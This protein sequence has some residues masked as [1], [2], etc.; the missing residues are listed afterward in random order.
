MAHNMSSQIGSLIERRQSA[1][2]PFATPSRKHTPFPQL[3]PHV[4]WSRPAT[5]QAPALELGSAFVPGVLGG[6][7]FDEKARI[8][9]VSL[10]L[11]GAVVLRRTAG[12]AATGHVSTVTHGL[13]SRKKSPPE[14]LSESRTTVG[15]QGVAAAGQTGTRQMAAV[16]W[17]LV[18][19]QQVGAARQ[20]LSSLPDDREYRKLRVLLQPPRTWSAPRRDKD[21][22]ADFRWLRQHGRD[23]VGR[24]VALSDGVLL[25]DDD[26]I[27]ALRN[28]LQQN[29]PHARPLIHLVQ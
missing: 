25:A 2:P 20:L 27:H 1:L 28:Q 8:T 17:S 23:Y 24:W 3:E 14:L 6:W 18:E 13:R 5:C 21:R 26:S 29:T 12:V 4:F 9:T 16:I 10:G 15:V 22:S 11:G 19:R 7:P